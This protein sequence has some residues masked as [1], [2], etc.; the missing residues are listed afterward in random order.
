VTIRNLETG[1]E[2]FAL[3]DSLVEGLLSMKKETL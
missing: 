3:L 2:R 1:E